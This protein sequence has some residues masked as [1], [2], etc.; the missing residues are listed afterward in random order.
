MKKLLV[1]IA[2]AGL[3]F[4]SF[5]YD[6]V[7]EKL[8]ESFK[9][10]FPKAGQVHWQETSAAFI[11]SFVDDNIRARAY[12]NRDGDLTQ[13][14]RYYGNA[15]APF[16]VVHAIQTQF[17]GKKIYGVTEVTTTDPKKNIETAYYV[18]LEDDRNWTTVKVDVYGNAV[19]T[20]KFRK[21]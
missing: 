10:S 3:G 14:I 15:H 11:V 5:A 21:A 1:L 8:I 7:N 12:Y 4:Q 2:V 16:V 19:V 6:P 9:A 18:K 13:L 17:K 20:Q